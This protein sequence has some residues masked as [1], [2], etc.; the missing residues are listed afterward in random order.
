MQSRCRYCGTAS[1]FSGTLEICVCGRSGSW[2]SEYEPELIPSRN[3]DRPTWL[4]VLRWIRYNLFPVGIEIERAA[5]E[6]RRKRRMEELDRMHR[7]F[8][9][10]LSSID[11]RRD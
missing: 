1:S 8:R 4:L 11:I 7:E 5:I 6:K 9:R 3:R 2:S 10:S